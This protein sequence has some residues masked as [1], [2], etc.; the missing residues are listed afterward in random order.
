MDCSS[1][2][3][4]NHGRGQKSCLKCKQY[5]DIQL[6]SVK[7]ETI[8]TEHIPQAIMDNIADPRTRD[9]MQIIKQ[10]PTQYSVPLLMRSLLGMSIQ[11]IAT[12]HAHAKSG[13]SKKIAKAI[14]IIKQ[15][16]LDG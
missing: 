1:C 4:Y 6:K 8:K 12:Y 5:K 9:L 16:L 2:P 13:V 3:Q 7:R 11:E 14:E 15:S 10:I